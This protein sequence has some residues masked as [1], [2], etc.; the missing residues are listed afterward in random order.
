MRYLDISIYRYP[1]CHYT[2]CCYMKQKYSI[3][4]HGQFKECLSDAVQSTA[5]FYLYEAKYLNKDKDSSHCLWIA[6]E[7]VQVRVF[8]NIGFKFIR[9]LFF[10]HKQP[11]WPWQCG[12][13][14]IIKE[15][16]HILSFPIF[17]TCFKINKY[18]TIQT[19][20]MITKTVVKILKLFE[21][22]TV[23]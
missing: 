5:L 23:V 21:T 19:S 22:C 13:S 6:Y 1:Y 18:N 20:E 7:V 15:Q 10:V 11:S 14:I 4:G 2:H 16:R 3:F 12:F 17:T 8:I 9:N